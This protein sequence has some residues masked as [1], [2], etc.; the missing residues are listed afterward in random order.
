MTYVKN[1][2]YDFKQ[3]DITI[4]RYIVD[5]TT[6]NSNDQH[7]LFEIIPTMHKLINSIRRTKIWPV[8]LVTQESRDFPVAGQDNDS[9]GFR[10]N[11]TTIK[12]G[13]QTAQSEISTLQT[14]Y[15]KIK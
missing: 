8:K 3:L 7:I 10:D 11:F 2:K 12:T 6:G 13:L 1:S 9:Q 14:Q 5:S 15:S 4:D